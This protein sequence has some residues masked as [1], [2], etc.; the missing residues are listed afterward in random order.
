MYVEILRM[1]IEMD[2]ELFDECKTEL[3]RTMFPKF[4]LRPPKEIK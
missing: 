3:R 1:M 2:P 4:K